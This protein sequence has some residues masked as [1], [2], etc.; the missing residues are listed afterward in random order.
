MDDFLT[1]PIEPER[2][3][4]TLRNHV[5]EKRASD[6]SAIAVQT[7]ADGEAESWPT[8]KGLDIAQARTLLMDSQSLFRRT[9]TNLVQEHRNLS[10]PPDPSIDEPTHAETREALASQVHKLKSVS[11]MVGAKAVHE[12]AGKTEKALRDHDESVRT[13]LTDLSEQLNDLIQN[14]TPF[15]SEPVS[16]N[17]PSSAQTMQTNPDNPLDLNALID[18]LNQR[19]LSVLDDI[20]AVEEQMRTLVGSENMTRLRNH[21][22][23]LEFQD[24]VQILQPFQNSR[25]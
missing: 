14:S 19:D 11:G 4:Q 2:L 8:I 23:R 6:T 5:G 20:D 15:L 21:L 17:H 1:K 18:K 3:I 9:L 12:L 25:M 16:A 10:T 7:I 13:L 24:V 22:G